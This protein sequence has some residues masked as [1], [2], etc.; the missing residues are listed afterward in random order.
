MFSLDLS[1]S[2]ISLRAINQTLSGSELSPNARR[3]WT[4]S[5]SRVGSSFCGSLR[6][7]GDSSHL[8]GAVDSQDACGGIKQSRGK[9]P[10]SALIN[11]NSRIHPGSSEKREG[12]PKRVLHGAHSHPAGRNK[13]EPSEMAGIIRRE[14]EVTSHGLVL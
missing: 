14:T 4:G 1:S 12:S 5:S 3:I 2:P 6:W 13:S 9:V 8:V 11:S 7:S 10:N